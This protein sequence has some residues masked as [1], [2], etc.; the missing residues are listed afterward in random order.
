MGLFKV[1]FFFL[2]F[3][4]LFRYI[5]KVF[6]MSGWNNSQPQQKTLKNEALVA[7]SKCG[8]YVPQSDLIMAGGK[9]FCS[10]NCADEP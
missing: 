6:V 5:K 7:C 10:K 1:I 2:F 9:S 3:W 8:V 4:S